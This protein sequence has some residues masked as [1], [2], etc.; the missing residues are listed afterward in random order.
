MKGKIKISEVRGYIQMTQNRI[1]ETLM[2]MV[3]DLPVPQ[4]GGYFL[5]C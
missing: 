3:M 5:T 1:H 2:K 4:K